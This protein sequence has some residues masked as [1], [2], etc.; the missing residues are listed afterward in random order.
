M[1]IKERA[2]YSLYKKQTKAGVVWYARFWNDDLEKYTIA[3]STGIIAAG[4][5]ERRGEAEKYVR[6]KLLPEIEKKTE[7][8]K[9]RLID[10]LLECWCPD[11]QMVISKELDLGRKISRDYITLNVRAIQKWVIPC[12]VLTRVTIGKLDKT[13][14]DTWRIWATK[15]GCG[16]RQL[17]TTLQAMKVPLAWATETERLKYNPLAIVKKPKYTPPDPGKAGKTFTKKEIE[18]IYSIV[19]FPDP[20]ALFAVQLSLLVGMRRGEL[21]GLRWGDI[22]KETRILT[23]QNNF[24]DAEGDKPCKWR[25]E[26]DEPRSVFLPDRIIPALDA[27]YTQSPLK[28]DSDYVLYYTDGKNILNNK[29]DTAK[30]LANRNRPCSTQVLQRGFIHLL[31]YIGITD[32]DRQKRRLTLHA[33]RSTAATMLRDAGIPDGSIMVMFGWKSTR[34]LEGYS[35]LDGVINR[36]AIG[37]TVEQNIFTNTDTQELTQDARCLEIADK[38][39]IDPGLVKL[40]DGKIVIE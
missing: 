25:A 40:V 12:A 5:K 22:N 36:Q 28:E 27:L 7:L 31:R 14:I 3:R 11:S 32:I 16:A 15:E 13:K 37:K 24:I 2:K 4:K 26:G 38:L 20:R 6:E 29:I 10:F 17:Q 34:V 18:A 39:G 8:T 23:I 1:N 19:D 35:R 33:C 30:I 21:R 9:Q